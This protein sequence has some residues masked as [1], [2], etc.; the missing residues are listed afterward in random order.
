MVHVSIDRDKCQGY[1][2]CIME[3]P[4]VFDLDNDGL[5]TL[6]DSGEIDA[7]QP[8]VIGAVKSCPVHALRL[9]DE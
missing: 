8:G 3:A 5:V 7:T 9:R 2:N 4:D 6:L 1:G